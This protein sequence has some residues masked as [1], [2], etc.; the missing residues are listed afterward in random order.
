[1][2]YGDIEGVTVSGWVD[3]IRLSYCKG[4]VFVAPLFIGTG[5]QNKLLEAMSLSIPCITTSLVNNALG[6][7]EN[8]HLL[9]AD[10]LET[11]CEKI[12]YLLDNQESAKEI[13]LQGKEF[14]REKYNWK[15]SIELIPLKK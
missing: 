13:A 12:R 9:I 8:K 7:K 4:K 14:I 11:F 6:A 10:T 2:K 3:D 15:A 1:M 5:L